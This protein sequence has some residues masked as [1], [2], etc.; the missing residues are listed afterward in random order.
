MKL[1]RFM[2]IF[3]SGHRFLADQDIPPLLDQVRTAVKD[4]MKTN[5]LTLEARVEWSKPWIG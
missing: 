2:L 3:M 5:P 4:G 1:T